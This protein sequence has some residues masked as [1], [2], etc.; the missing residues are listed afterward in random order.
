M[1]NNGFKRAGDLNDNG[2]SYFQRAGSLE[3]PIKVNES[4]FRPAG[5]LD[6]PV[7]NN[8]FKFAEKEET[9]QTP[10]EIRN[11]LK[12]IVSGKKMSNYGFGEGPQVIGA[13]QKF[14]SI[15]ELQNMVKNGDNIIKAEYLDNMNMVMIEFESFSIP[16][17]SR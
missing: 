7:Q 1:E 10:E 15:E 5:D 8:S 4:L 9:I 12:T 16:S 17:K 2:M 6:T 13:G 3:E 14:V 11:W